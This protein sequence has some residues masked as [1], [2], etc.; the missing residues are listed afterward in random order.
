MVMLF[1]IVVQQKVWCLDESF[2][3]IP[4]TFEIGKIMRLTIPRSQGKQEY[5]D[6]R[7]SGW[8]DIFPHPPKNS[9][10]ERH[11][12]PRAKRE[13]GTTPVTGSDIGKRRHSDR[14]KDRPSY[15]ALS[16]DVKDNRKKSRRD[17]VQHLESDRR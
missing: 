4:D 7:K 3:L 11:Q 2:V 17:R 12:P 1:L 6:A 13:G 5:Y 9:P 14:K 16:K 8:G 10:Q 15:D